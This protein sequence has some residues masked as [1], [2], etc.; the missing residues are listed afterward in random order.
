MPKHKG[1]PKGFTITA[2]RGPYV[3]GHGASNAKLAFV[4]EAPGAEEE[5]KGLPF[6]GPAG[7][8]LNQLLIEAGI[9]REECYLTNISKYRPPLNKFDFLGQIGVNLQDC[10][11]ALWK[12]LNALPNLNLVVALGDH[13]LQTLAGKKGITK[14]RGSLLRPLYGNFKVLATIHPSA[15]LRSENPWDDNKLKTKRMVTPEIVTVDLIKAK[16]ESEIQGFVQPHRLIEI[17]KDANK[18]YKFVNSYS[19]EIP[20]IDIEAYKCIPTCIAIAPTPWHVGVIPL[21]PIAGVNGELRLTETEYVDLWIELA[22]YLNDPKLKLV[23]QNIKYDLE[24]LIAPA[25]LLHPFT[26]DKVHADISMMMG[27]A[28]PELPRK[29][30]FSTSIF[31]NEP[32]Y[33]DE[34]RE[35]NPKKDSYEVLLNY[36][37]KDAAVTKEIQIALDKELG[38]TKRSD[39]IPQAKHDGDTTSLKDFYYRYINRLT[40]FYMDM[41][42]EGLLVDIDRQSWLISDYR[43]KIKALHDENVSIIKTEYNPR[44]YTKDV[45]EIIKILGLPPRKSYGEDELVALMGN[46]T[47]PDSPAARFIR[48]MLSERQAHTNLNYLE[49]KTDAD[50]Y[51]RTSWNPT[52]TETG[53]SSTSN[54]SPPLRPFKGKPNQ[55]GLAFQTLPKHGPFAEQIQSIFISEPGHVFIE[56]DYSQAEARIVALLSDDAETLE[57]F[58]THDIHSLTS[59]WIYGGEES[60]IRANHEDQRFIGKTTRHAGNY[61]EGKRRLM[62]NANADA[63]KFGIPVQISEKE[64]GRILDV[65]HKK[66]PKIRGVFQK[67]VRDIVQ[68]D[69]TLWNPY[70][71]MRQFFGVLK[72]TEA[73]AQ[74]PQSTVPDSLRMA[75]LRLKDKYPWL[76]FVLEKHDSFTWIVPENKVDEVLRITKEEMEV[77]I[78]F[79]YCSLSRGKIIIPTEAKIG[80]RLSELKKAKE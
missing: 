29:L 14:F 65:F 59:T 12:E 33:K 7:Q 45:P 18:F 35:F 57:L 8:R 60:D 52:G 49:A 76:R 39:Y 44:S 10:Q 58:D 43:S 46:H 37:G 68:K 54:L 63:T 80:T 16:K 79:R 27:V 34:G 73:Y 53:R 75:G 72:D 22:R 30:E 21:M 17:I 41:E 42:A 47:T 71:R 48:N 1:I 2:K 3:P 13:P 55:I 28:Y 61:G 38:E 77:S 9:N 15:L 51:M 24:K 5:Q 74:I 32:F 19:G 20:A 11:T 78:D 56:R 70:G 69:R 67:E 36:N 4:G 66:T 64:A 26:K 62:L 31:T 6:V 25:K 40:D 23:G 50:G